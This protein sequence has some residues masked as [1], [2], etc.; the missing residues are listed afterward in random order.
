MESSLTHGVDNGQERFAGG[1]AGARSGSGCRTSTRSKPR[2]PL[3]HRLRLRAHR[4]DRRRD[5]AT[6]S[7]TSCTTSTASS[8]ALG[9]DVE[10]L[11]GPAMQAEVHSPTY[12]GRP[13]AQ[14]PGRARRSGPARV[15][16][17]GGGRVASACGS[18]RTRRPRAS[19]AMASGRSSTTP[20]GRVRA[21]KVALGHQRL[22]AAPATAA[23]L[24]R[25]RLRL[26]AGHRTAVAGPARVHRMEAAPR[27]V[28]LRRTSSTTTG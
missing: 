3:R 19:T 17:E 28:R 14:G 12:H 4:R 21:G 25:A 11:D 10:F 24:H 27:P 22:P 16:A 23:A 7:S 8:A 5:L 9:Q 2:S 6:T 26:R 13:V 18:T 15:G 20:L 1:D